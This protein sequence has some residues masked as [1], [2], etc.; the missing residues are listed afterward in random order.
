MK[1]LVLTRRAAAAPALAAAVSHRHTLEPVEPERFLARLGSGGC[2]LVIVDLDGAGA[3]DEWCAKIR[4][5]HRALP[6][7]ALTREGDVAARVRALEHGADDALSRPGAPSQIA[8]RVDALGRRAALA[9]AEPER[10]EADGATIDLG[11]AVC[12]RDG[13][14]VRLTAREVELV[15][16]LVRHAGRPV[17]R[18]A[19]LEHVWGVAPTIETRAV[20]VAVAELRKKLERDPARPALVVSVRGLGYA[21]RPDLT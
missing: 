3:E 13:R 11:R 7:L 9:P 14:T 19:L 20:D 5:A 6:V 8:A 1:I 10:I 15:R 12:E 18:A 21:W 17:A 2:D 16:W 4:A